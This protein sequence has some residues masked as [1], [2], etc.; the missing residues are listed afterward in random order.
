MTRG[1]RFFIVAG[2][3]N[4]FGDTLRVGLERHFAA[5]IVL[6][7]VIVVLGFVIAAHLL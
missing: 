1:L 5:F 4:L 3:L 6:S 2:V 7:A